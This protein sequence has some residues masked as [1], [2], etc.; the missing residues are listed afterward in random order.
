M[1]K[2]IDMLLQK[3]TKWTGKTAHSNE[4]YFWFKILLLS[5]V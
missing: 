2:I 5:I 1:F 4:I 3:S